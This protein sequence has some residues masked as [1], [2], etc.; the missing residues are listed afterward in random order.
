MPWINLK[1]KKGDYIRHKVGEPH[2][3]GT[4][5]VVEILKTHSG[6]F[7]YRVIFGD[8]TFTREVGINRSEFVFGYKGIEK[9]YKLDT[10]KMR[11]LKLKELL[12]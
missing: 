1:F 8:D 6:S 9:E 2:D 11:Q 12:K 10:Q 5:F 4:G 7:S 3:W